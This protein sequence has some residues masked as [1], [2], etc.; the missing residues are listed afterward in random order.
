MRSLQTVCAS[1]HR[2]VSLALIWITYIQVSEYVC[3]LICAQMRPFLHMRCQ[4]IALS[5]RLGKA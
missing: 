3:P 5:L 4:Q 2:G 1:M